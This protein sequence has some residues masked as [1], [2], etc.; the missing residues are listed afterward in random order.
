VIAARVR[1]AHGE[2]DD[3]DADEEIRKRQ[4]GS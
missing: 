4:H 3:R 2:Q 1:Q